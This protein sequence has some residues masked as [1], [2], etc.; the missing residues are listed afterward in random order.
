[1]VLHALRDRLPINEAVQ[2]GAQFPI[3]IRGVYYEGWNPAKVPIKM[4]KQDFIDRV[5]NEYDFGEVQAET[6]VRVVLQALSEHISEGEMEDIELS[7][8][9][10]L[11]ELFP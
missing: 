2:L 10:S 8:P 4:K 1:M 11:R 7:L 3:V 5:H 9:K 6:I